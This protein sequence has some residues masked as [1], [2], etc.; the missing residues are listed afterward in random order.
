LVLLAHITE[1]EIPDKLC[2]N[3]KNMD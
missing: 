2:S 3:S 1:K